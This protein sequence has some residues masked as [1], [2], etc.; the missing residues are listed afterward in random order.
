MAEK[1]YT[2]VF[3]AKD[4][5]S[6]AVRQM[7]QTLAK[8]KN[9]QELFIKKIN[10]MD[11]EQKEYIQTTKRTT[12]SVDR[13]KRALVGVGSG[14]ATMG[15]RGMTAVRTLGGG[16]KSIVSTITS[17][18]ALIAG[19]GTAFGAWK[20]GDMVIGGGLRQEMTLTQLQGLSGSKQAGN[21]IY[22]ML[23]NEAM[24]STFA[25]QEYTQATR[26]FLGFTRDQEELK[27]FLDITKRLALLDPEQGFSGASFAVKEGLAGDLLSLS[28]RFEIPKSFLRQNG[29]DS[30]GGYMA[31]YTAISKTL[32]QMG[33]T[34]EAVGVYE[35]T[36]MAKLTE[37]KNKSLDW[38]GQMGNGVVKEMKPFF[39]EINKF[40]KSSDAKNFA[41]EM[42]VWLGGAF[43]RGVTYLKDMNLTWSD[44]ESVF[45]SAGDIFGGVGDSFAIMMGTF[46]G[47]KGNSPRDAFE[48]FAK[49]LEDGGNAIDRFNESFS[50]FVD[51]LRAFADF[52][53]TFFDKND[54]GTR[55]KG[56]LTWFADGVTGKGWGKTYDP[57]TQVTPWQA[58]KETFRINGQLL[59]GLNFNPN[60]GSSGRLRGSHRAGL[61]YVPY[62]GY[63]AELHKGEQ[64]VPAQAAQRMGGQVLITNNTFN[65]R[66][67]SDIDA[68][69]KAIANELRLKGAM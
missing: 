1:R 60:A 12:E 27:G 31:N 19:A 48:Q 34:K 51:N 25:T 59:D 36:G 16:L 53:T 26:S 66:N 17:L 67:E 64:V 5:F 54:D 63:V 61:S 29:F 8:A 45:S 38:L 3:S 40:F 23:R 22:Q 42:S 4:H 49:T 20:L 46:N 15:N 10:E 41:N 32:D 47:E 56:L 52:G 50:P 55:D 35:S 28:E 44:F 21:E 14:F 30:K 65:V 39:T 69:G 57:S 9:E 2:A 37:F 7:Q 24:N 62:D 11:K 58:L 33:M 43:N 6:P 68:I 13:M 18:P